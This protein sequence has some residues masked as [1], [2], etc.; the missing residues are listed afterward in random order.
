MEKEKPK[1]NVLNWKTSF[2]NMTPAKALLF[3]II[4]MVLTIFSLKSSYGSINDGLILASALLNTIFIMLCY[5]F[6]CSISALVEKVK[7]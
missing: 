7:R 4:L 3:G 5:V 1:K 6:A 2:F